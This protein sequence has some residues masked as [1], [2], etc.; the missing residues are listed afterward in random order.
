MTNPNTLLSTIPELKDLPYLSFVKVEAGIF[1]MGS[2]SEDKDAYNDKKSHR[3]VTIEQ[4]FWM[5]A[6]PVSQAFW[7]AVMGENPSRFKDPNR[8]VEKVSWNAIRQQ[9]GFLERINDKL[10]GSNGSKG[11]HFR[12]PS[13]AQWEYAAIG[14]PFRK[15]EYLY[16]GS[17]LLETQGYFTEN[18]QSEGS[19]CLGLKAPN[20]LGLYDM[21]GQVW[22]LCEDDWHA[23]YTNAPKTEVAWIFS[24]NR[25]DYRV[26]RGGSWHFGRWDA[27]V[28]NRGGDR[29]VNSWNRQGFRLVFV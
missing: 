16:A 25:G 6:Y 29:P 3:T 27:R 11:G 22:E 10:T 24:P 14:G 21:S 2:L 17:D 12:L 18:T 1:R 7:E 23:D 26:G 8:P 28:A 19:E 4:D 9:G 15:E 5:M 13:E 20:A